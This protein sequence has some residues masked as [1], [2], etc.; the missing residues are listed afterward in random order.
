[1]TLLQ[2]GCPSKA[3]IH[4]HSCER[5]CRKRHRK[6]G[7]HEG[8]EEEL[9][10]CALRVLRGSRLLCFLRQPRKW[11]LTVDSTFAGVTTAGGVVLPTPFRHHRVLGS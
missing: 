5:G 9:F 4:D 6:E 11:E 10:L 3:L 2:A 8:H 1:M 7:N